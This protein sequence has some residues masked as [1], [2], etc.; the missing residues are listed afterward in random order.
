MQIMR[1]GQVNRIHVSLCEYLV[2]FDE[3]LWDTVALCKCPR[4]FL[5]SVTA[6]GESDARN[7]PAHQGGEPGNIA[8][9]N[10]GKPDAIYSVTHSNP[11][12]RICW[13]V[14]L[15]MLPV[16]CPGAA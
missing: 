5:I 12:C 8:A 10:H 7:Q 13:Y 14:W 4:S 16:V 15:R 3:H 11:R 1:H 2:V 9:A 6:G